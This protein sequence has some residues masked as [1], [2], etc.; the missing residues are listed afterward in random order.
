MTDR[1]MLEF[2]AK[3][4]GLSIHEAHDDYLYIVV[5]SSMQIVM[6]APRDDDGDAFRLMVALNMTVAPDRDKSRMA[7]WASL[8]GYAYSE[9]VDGDAC[10]AL[11][12]AITKV[13]AKI[14]RTP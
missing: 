14:G 12:L 8:A 2:A 6:W 13:A 1:E 7:A 3:A 4:M 9:I 5:P 10:A 11:R